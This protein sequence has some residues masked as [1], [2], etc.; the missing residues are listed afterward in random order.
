MKLKTSLLL[1][2]LAAIVIWL[3]VL[4]IPDNKLHVYFCDVGQGD[5]ALIVQG[6]T[7][8]VIDMGPDDSILNCLSNYMPFYDHQIEAAIITHPQQDHMGGL[9]SVIQNY[10]LLQLFIPP[11]ENNIRVYRK[12]LAENAAG[13]L[14]VLNAY[15]GDLLKL[16]DFQF[17]SVWPSREFVEEHLPS[18]ATESAKVLGVTTDGSDLIS[19]AVVGYLSYGDFDIL[20]TGDADA[21]VESAELETGLLRPVEVLKVPHHGSKT[22]MIDEWL[23]VLK[24]QVAVISVGKNNSYHHPTNKALE[25]L[26]KFTSDIHRTDLEG[27]IEIV[28]DGK[29]WW[30]KN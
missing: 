30:V 25:Q 13:K 20:F 23:D 18:I 10:S 21:P 6:L 5:G 1:L 16:H 28:S 17:Q 29:K 19:F 22:G 9:T 2:S 15:T 24:P 11:A 26:S 14:P 4:A 8:L 3:A 27:T 12:L 7:Q